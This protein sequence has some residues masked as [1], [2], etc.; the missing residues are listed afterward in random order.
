[1]KSLNILIALIFF[2]MFSS[3]SYAGWKTMDETVN[4]DILYVDFERIQKND[5]YV[6]FWYLSDYLKPDK[7]GQFSDKMYIQGD[8][9]L[10]RYKVLSDSFYKKPMGRGDI[11][12]GSNVPDKEWR[13]PS[14]NSMNEVILKTVCSR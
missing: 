9:K 14:L 11:L 10:F 4:G 7:Y 8:C 1:M 6:Y 13:Y 3:S 5:G 12:S 2:G